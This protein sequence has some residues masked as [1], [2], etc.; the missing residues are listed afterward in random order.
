MAAKP[1]T[2]AEYLASV[3]PEQRAALE[4]LRKTLRAALPK[5]EEVISYGIP[6][7]RHS[8]GALIGFGS[9]TKHCS[10][11]LFDGS[12]VEAHKTELKAYKTSKGAIQFAPD[13]PLPAALVRKLVK[14][15]VAANDK[16]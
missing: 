3:P 1:K 10:F 13:K 9:A 16:D 11:F 14:A 2:H 8:N 15:R 5:A 7:F 6:A 4:A 12:T